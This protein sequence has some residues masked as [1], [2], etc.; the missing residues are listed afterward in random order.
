SRIPIVK[1]RWESRRGPEFTWE[2]EDQMKAKSRS[3]F[4]SFFLL[5]F[6][7]QFPK[8]GE[9]VTPVYFYPRNHCILYLTI[10]KSA[11]LFH[12]IYLIVPSLSCVIKLLFLVSLPNP[13][14]VKRTHEIRLNNKN[15]NNNL[16]KINDNIFF[17][18]CF[19][20][21]TIIIIIFNNNNNK[22]YNSNDFNNNNNKY[23]NT[24]IKCN[25]NLVKFV[26]LVK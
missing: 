9:T 6:G 26:R 13:I 14:V 22:L 15:N 21:I 12:F 4:L 16:D 25:G 8:V 23:N 5:N 7:T 17:I 20:I 24:Q 18:I 1:V 10:N 3:S 2:R 19:I 11:S